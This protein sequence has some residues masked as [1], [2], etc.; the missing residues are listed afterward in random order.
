MGMNGETS[1]I[2]SA[3]EIEADGV[4][5]WGVTIW[6]VEEEGVEGQ[7]ISAWRA[8]AA[9]KRGL[10]GGGGGLGGGAMAKVRK[11]QASDTM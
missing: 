8:S 9:E 7:T 1:A 10:G 11:T 5:F 2:V 3:R 6:W 4:G